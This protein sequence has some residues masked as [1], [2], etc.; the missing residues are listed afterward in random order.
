[1]GLIDYGQSKQLDNK[2]RLAFASLILEMTRG[3]AAADPIVVSKRLQQ[4]GLE[5]DND[6]NLKIQA[7]MA[8]GMFDT[9]LSHK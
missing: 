6:D 5:F 3:K 1:M 4:M 2:T 9:E 7:M 8:F